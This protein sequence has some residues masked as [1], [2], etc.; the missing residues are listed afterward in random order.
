VTVATMHPVWIVWLIWLLLAVVLYHAIDTAGSRLTRRFDDAVGGFLAGERS[1]LVCDEA[2]FTAFNYLVVCLVPYLL[3]L[4]AFSLLTIVMLAVT[5]TEFFSASTVVGPL[6]LV[7]L[8]LVTLGTLGAIVAGLFRLLFPPRRSLG[9]VEITNSASPRLWELVRGVAT[10]AGLQSID[11][12][13][14]VPTPGIGVYLEGGY[15]FGLL[16]HSRRVLEIGLGALHG[17]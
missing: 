9:T 16:G 11:K 8:I 10:A 6:L 2:T 14:I 15:C 7:G 5:I 12:V 13:V 1:E 4:L 17:L 3:Y